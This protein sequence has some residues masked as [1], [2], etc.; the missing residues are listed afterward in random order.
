MQS[1]SVVAWICNQQVVNHRNRS[2]TSHRHC[3]LQ[4]L[5]HVSPVALCHQHVSPGG[6]V[7]STC[8]TRWRCVINMFHQVALRY[9]HVSPV[10]LRYQHVSPVALCHQHVSPVA[11]C[12]QHVSPVALCHQHVSPAGVVSSTCFTRWRCVINMFHQVALCHQH[13]SPAG[14]VSST[15]FTR[16]RCV[17][18]MFH[19]W[20]CVINM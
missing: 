16:W 2:T 1:T 7:S 15:C 17:I 8:F 19:Q 6:V 5:A 14:V 10:A 11:L 20:H 9:Q 18:N 3:V 13:V 4:Q 12:H